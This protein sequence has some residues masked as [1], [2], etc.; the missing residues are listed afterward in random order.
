MKSIIDQIVFLLKEPWSVANDSDSRFVTFKESRQHF[1]PFER[2]HPK[3]RNLMYKMLEIQP[4]LRL[5]MEK[6]LNDEWIKSIEYC[7]G[8]ETEMER[9]LHLHESHSNRIC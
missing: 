5:T 4:D 3:F 7:H 6:V 2:L 8:N 1:S 9:M